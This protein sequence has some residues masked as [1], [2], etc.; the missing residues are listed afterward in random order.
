MPD[1]AVKASR[2]YRTPCV[3]D[4]VLVRD[5]QLSKEKGKKLEPRWSTPRVLSI[6]YFASQFI[7]VPNICTSPF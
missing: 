7:A 1:M 4:F 5:I 2:G 6:H 3:G